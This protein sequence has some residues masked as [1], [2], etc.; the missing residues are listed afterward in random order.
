[1]TQKQTPEASPFD[2]PA[3]ILSQVASG[4]KTPPTSDDAWQV[5]H[6]AHAQRL[7]SA[8]GGVLSRLGVDGLVI[9]SGQSVLKYS[10]DDQYWPTAMTPNFAHWCPYAETPAFLV[11]RPGEKPKLITERH[12][13]FWEGPAPRNLRWD[14]TSFDVEAVDDLG[15]LKWPVGYAFIGDDLKLALKTGLVIEQCNRADLLAAA[16]G[17]RTLKSDY[18]I[19]SMRVAAEVAAR[20]HNHLR[21]L[22][23]QGPVSEFALHLE[24]LRLTEQSDFDL[25]YGNIV[26]LGANCG[27]LHHVHY[28]RKIIDGA[29]SLLVDAG[30]TCNGFASDITRTWVRGSSEMAA[31]FGA[32][33]KAVDKAQRELVK[34]VTVGRRYEDLHNHAHALLAS[35]LKDSG[36]VTCSV[37]EMVAAGLTR[38]FFPHGLGHS[39]GIQVH[40][41]GMKLAKPSAEN[42]YLRNTSMITAGQVVTIEP[43]IYFIPK[44]MQDALTGPKKAFVNEALVKGLMPFGGIRIEDDILVTTQGPINLTRDLVFE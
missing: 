29:T 42:P 28:D 23:D 44:L 10:R 19:A 34:G 8:W 43:G 11:I 4:V 26:A 20:G 16:D 27:I 31:L 14:Q 2:L 13:S 18:E 17:F 24:Y 22:F 39:L 37:D 36:L 41:V 5:L 6:R 12:Q 32:L 21:K 7:Q 30:A 1:M 40:D 38:L 3:V 9:H 35:V 25:P 33:I 15:A